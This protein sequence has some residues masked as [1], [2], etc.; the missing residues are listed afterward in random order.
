MC[1]VKAMQAGLQTN[2]SCW[3]LLRLCNLT[4]IQRE[5][6]ALHAFPKLPFRDTLLT[7]TAPDKPQKD[8][9]MIPEVS[10][11]YH[12]HIIR[13]RPLQISGPPTETGLALSRMMMADVWQA[14]LVACSN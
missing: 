8:A 2:E 9:L 14:S 11:L 13:C 3:Y 5:W 12:S 10:F 1:R 4:T 7:A 6:C